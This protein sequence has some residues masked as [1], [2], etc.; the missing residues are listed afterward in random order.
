MLAIWAIKHSIYDQRLAETSAMQTAS[1]NA[2]VIYRALQR[3]SPRNSSSTAYTNQLAIDC[4]F[5]YSESNPPPKALRSSLWRARSISY[6]SLEHSCLLDGPVASALL[7]TSTSI[8]SRKNCLVNCERL[9]VWRRSGLVEWT[10]R[11][12]CERKEPSPSCCLVVCSRFIQHGHRSTVVALSYH[13]I[14]KHRETAAAACC[15][16]FSTHCFCYKITFRVIYI[17]APGAMRVATTAIIKQDRILFIPPLS[18]YML[19]W[20]QRH[21]YIYNMFL[22]SERFRR[23]VYNGGWKLSSETRLYK[24]LVARRADNW[25]SDES[26]ASKRTS[27]GYYIT[28]LVILYFAPGT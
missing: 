12:C 7:R 18:T 25:H 21:P 20:Q 22:V 15:T 13:N 24:A 8:D 16:A 28:S 4:R 23:A 3:Q 14:Y 2:V 11:D 19:P 17:L 5:A 9:G 27:S 10:D 6:T 1:L 26:S